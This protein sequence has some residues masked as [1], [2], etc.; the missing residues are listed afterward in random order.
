MRFDAW[1]RGHA[2]ISFSDGEADSA[3][4]SSQELYFSLSIQPTYTTA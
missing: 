1:L 2:A 4:G 3:A